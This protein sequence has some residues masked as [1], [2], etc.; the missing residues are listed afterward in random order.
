MF[1]FHNTIINIYFLT[2]DRL[3]DLRCL[4]FKPWN[5]ADY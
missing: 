4:V 1:K 5:S 3:P 2:S